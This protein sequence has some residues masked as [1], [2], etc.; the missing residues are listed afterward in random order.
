M[1]RFFKDKTI[2]VT[3]GC[4]SIGSKIVKNILNYKPKVVR[5]LDNNEA[6]IFELENELSNSKSVRFLIGDIRDK[7][8]VS[9]AMEDVDVVFHAAA[10]KHVP[11]CEFNPFEAVKTNVLGTENVI[12]AAYT[13]NVEKVI[14]ISTDKV[15]NPVSTMGATKLLAEKIM[16]AANYYRGHKKTVMATVRFGNVLSSSGSVIPLFENQISRKGPVTITHPDM[17]R[18]IM[19][20]DRTVELVFN[21]VELMKG[22]EI[23]I[24]K[25]PV[26]RIKD[27][28]KVMIDNVASK[29]GHQ[30][31]D[32]PVKVIGLRPGEKMYEDIMTENEASSCYETQDMFIVQPQIMV[33]A[34]RFHSASE[35]PGAKKS[36]YKSYSS[37][38]FEP[39][40]EDVIK[41]IV[42][43]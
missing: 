20:T 5:V 42:F 10:L 9:M 43:G 11:L 34:D 3:G 13:H 39:L 37:K 17:L 30:P 31:K 21:A 33:D 4:G 14:L 8:R 38:D 32:V 41:K 40:K 23:F 15:V 2:L 12:K 1:D 18:F 24:L 22:G 25:M 7:E 28:A 29:Y 36:S 27:L 16:S 6:A 19:S 35:Y 26:I